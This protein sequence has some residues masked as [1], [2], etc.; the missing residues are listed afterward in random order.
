MM[1]LQIIRQWGS[2][3][4]TDINIAIVVKPAITFL[5]YFW[6]SP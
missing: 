6:T 1:S 4:N 2:A 5:P 3:L